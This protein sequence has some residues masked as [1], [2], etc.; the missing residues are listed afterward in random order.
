VELDPANERDARVG[1]EFLAAVAQR[2]EKQARQRAAQQRQR[3]QLLLAAG[4]LELDAGSASSRERLSAVPLRAAVDPTVAHELPAAVLP[5]RKSGR[6]SSSNLDL[7]VAA[8]N[9]RLAGAGP[10]AAGAGVAGASDA[11]AGDDSASRR[12]QAKASRQHD[13]DESKE[14]D[15]NEVSPKRRRS[16][17][18]QSPS[19]RPSGPSR[20]NRSDR[21]LK[22][23]RLALQARRRG[24]A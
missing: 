19:K 18:Q 20:G 14:L 17:L 8:L 22:G 6:R 16:L 11:V 21:P 15:V 2:K 3:E 12:A 1:R 23:K 24:L 5:K 13:R 4:K 10:A 9:V 7:E